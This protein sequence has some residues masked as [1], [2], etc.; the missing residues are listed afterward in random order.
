MRYKRQLFL[1]PFIVLILS[2]SIIAQR[3]PGP[4]L[5]VNASVGVKPISPYIY[6][7][8]FADEAFASEID[9]PVNRWGGNATTRYNYQTDTANHAMDW[10]FENIVKDDL[11]PNRVLPDGSAA[12][13]F[14]EQNIRTGTQ[15]LLTIPMIGWV[16]KPQ[17]TRIVCGFSVAKYGAQQST[18]P[19]APD[20]GNGRHP[21]GTEMTGND[22]TDTS[23]AITPAFVQGWMTHLSKYGTAATGGVR[24]YN[25]D[26]EV[27]LWNDTHRDVHPEPVSYDMLRDLTYQYA[28]AIKA[29][30]PNAQT[31]GPVEYGYTAYFYSALD[32][33]AG[34]GFWNNP[35]DRNAHGGVPLVEW[36]LQQMQAYEQ[37]HG[38]RIL[39]YLDLHYYP[40]Q[41]G[42]ALN[43]AGDANTQALRLRSTRS[44]WDPTYQD[45]S[46]IQYSGYPPVRLIPMMREWIENNYPGTKI[47]ITEYNFGGL[48]HIN[49]AL[50]QAD[51]LGIFGREGVGLATIWSPPQPNQPGAYAFRVYRNYDGAGGKFGDTSVQA[52]SNDQGKLSIY[53]ATRSSDGAL[54]LVIINKTGETQTSTTTINGF[55]P[56]TASQVY[57]YSN[58]NL[59]AIVRQADQGVVANTFTRDYPANSITVVVIPNG[60]PTTNT[61]LLN[62]GDFEVN[63][64]GNNK[65]PDAWT[66]SALTKDRLKCDTF[67]GQF[68]FSGKCA[69]RFVGGVGE[70]AKLIQ[71]VDLTGRTFAA[72][73]VLSITVHYKTN[74][75]KPRLKIKGR[76]FYN[77]SITPAGKLNGTINVVA[78]TYMSFTVPT[79]H[80][81]TESNVTKIKVQF[82]NRATSGKIYIDDASLL[83][84]QAAAR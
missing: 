59:N 53:A 84:T 44:L 50:A 4:Q 34:D 26:N 47:A 43:T 24:F 51:V 12:D 20:C 33:E 79:T 37:T 28:A 19:W 60:T 65:V 61:E 62:D 83:W 49:G 48:E 6:G 78:P 31:L 13:L 74:N 9:L 41:P 10:Y 2:T 40:A 29:Q 35:I 3:V 36:Y 21:N 58:A 14:V 45:E 57:T 54:T 72:G 25:L 55:N 69:F 16:P 70:N 5:T 68:S 76:V 38:V 77:N 30:D 67:V 81:L 80:I 63:L 22:P 11:T 7:L 52:V 71:N 42:V 1:I 66:F 8:N 18:D 75:V 23:M 32:W 64:D 15:T 39:D 73:N 17:A 27:S 56:A 82:Q 46:W